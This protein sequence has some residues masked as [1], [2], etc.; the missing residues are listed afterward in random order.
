M[1]YIAQ[2]VPTFTTAD[3]IEYYCFSEALLFPWACFVLLN[4]CSAA[5]HSGNRN[6]IAITSTLQVTLLQT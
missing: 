6:T 4:L 3:L 5:F 2:S 1:K